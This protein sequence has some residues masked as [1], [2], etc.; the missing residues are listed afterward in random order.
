MRRPTVYSLR[1]L[2][3]LALTLLRPARR[4]TALHG[5]Q[6]RNA[7]VGTDRNAAG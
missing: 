5:V 6:S 7:A 4:G 1:R 2:V 3:P